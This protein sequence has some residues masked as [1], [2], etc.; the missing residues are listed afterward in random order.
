VLISPNLR[1]KA[2]GA[3]LLGGPWGRQIAWIGTGGENSFEPVNADHARYWTTRH[4]SRV[5]AEMMALVGHVRALQA[6]WVARP[7]VGQACRR[8]PDESGTTPPPAARDR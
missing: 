4:P 6:D 7:C 2:A 3:G 8:A 5:L 1:P